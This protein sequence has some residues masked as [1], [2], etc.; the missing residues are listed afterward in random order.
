MT[1]L[2]CD[3]CGMICA[4]LAFTTSR[5]QYRLLCNEPRV[6]AMASYPEYGAVLHR[7]G[8]ASSARLVRMCIATLGRVGWMPP[9]S[10]A[11]GMCIE[12]ARTRTGQRQLVV[13]SDKMGSL[14]YVT[15][16]GFRCLA[17]VCAEVLL[18]IP[19]TR[20]AWVD[21]RGGGARLSV[22]WVGARVS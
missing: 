22:A 18:A 8:R 15:A 2:P 20:V 16:T 7:V 9:R 3:V 14:C 19:R 21:V 11:V 13:V 12:V 17:R 6:F 10:T 4:V 1:K 5:R